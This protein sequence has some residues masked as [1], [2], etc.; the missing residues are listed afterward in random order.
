MK[1]IDQLQNKVD[2]KIYKR[3]KKYY[4][5]GRV[6]NY[7][8]SFG[9]PKQ[10]NIKAQVIGSKH[11]GI[12]LSLELSNN[13]LVFIGQCSCPYD[14]GPIC[15]HKVAVAYK[16]LNE[17]YSQLDSTSLQKAN[18]NKLVTLS[19]ELSQKEVDLK[20]FVKGLLADSMVNFKLKLESKD[21]SL[22]QLEEVIKERYF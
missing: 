18:F 6:I 15:K 8:Y 3:G 2:R 20:Y 19:K 10:V 17:D 5:Q 14:W 9:G 12:S 7:N 22:A 11:Y 1:L 4:K 13:Q 16:F 21:L